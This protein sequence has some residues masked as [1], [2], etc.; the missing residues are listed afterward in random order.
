MRLFRSQSE[1][2]YIGPSI[3]HTRSPEPEL[4]LW[5]TSGELNSCPP[6]S[7]NPHT[8]FTVSRRSWIRHSDITAG[9]DLVQSVPNRSSTFTDVYTPKQACWSASVIGSVAS[10]CSERRR[11]ATDRC[12]VVCSSFASSLY[13]QQPLFKLVWTAAEQ[14]SS[15]VSYVT[16][17]LTVVSAKLLLSSAHHSFCVRQSPAKLGNVV[18]SMQRQNSICKCNACVDG[19]SQNYASEGY[20]RKGHEKSAVGRGCPLRRGCPLHIG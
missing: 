6:C 11:P 3:S 18:R 5:T 12:S 9:A 19:R 15:D 13:P 16:H 20:R 7:R 14:D 1:E 17:S 4:T 2:L 10:P 8:V